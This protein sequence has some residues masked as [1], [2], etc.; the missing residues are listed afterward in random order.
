MD[1]RKINIPYFYVIESTFPGRGKKWLT[2]S[3]GGR[4]VQS[5]IVLTP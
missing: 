2:K 1:L 5:W 4:C 3:K